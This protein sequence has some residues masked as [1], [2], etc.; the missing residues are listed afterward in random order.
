M[1]WKRL[2]DLLFFVVLFPFVFPLFIVLCISIYA[3][4]GPPILFVQD[5]GG[6]HGKVIKL[7]KFRSMTQE[8]DEQGN[9]LPDEMRLGKFGGILRSLS[10]DEIPSMINLVKGDITLVGPRPFIADYL[11]LYTPDQFRRH[12]V[13]PGITGWAQVNGRNLLSWDE[14]FKLDVWYV[15][16]RTFW[17]D[18]KILWLTI[19]Q[20]I[21]RDGISAAGCTT[22]PRFTGSKTE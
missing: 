1:N 5:R 13:T 17:L 2:F 14:K 8:T 19:K 15:D 21:T 3:V 11:S 7:Y 6:L 16:N 10:L 12:E 20:V 9:L 22:M 4:L 18:L